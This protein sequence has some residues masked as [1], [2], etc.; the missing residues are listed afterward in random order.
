MHPLHP[1]IGFE[2][3]PTG[4]AAFYTS[5]VQKTFQKYMHC[6]SDDWEKSPTH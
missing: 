3:T 4:A 1:G 2:P 5:N 6:V